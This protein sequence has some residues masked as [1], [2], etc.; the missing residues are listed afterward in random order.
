[1]KTLYESILDDE[2]IIYQNTKENIIR[3]SFENCNVEIGRNNITISPGENYPPTICKN[4]PK[5]YKINVKDIGVLTIRSGVNGDT[6]ERVVSDKPLILEFI[7]KW[8][9]GGTPPSKKTI[10]K[11]CELCAGSFRFHYPIEFQNCTLKLSEKCVN[12]RFKINDIKELHKLR[13]DTSGT[14][15]VYI[16]ICRTPLGDEM[17]KHRDNDKFWEKIDK[18]LNIIFQPLIQ[19]NKSCAIRYEDNWARAYSSYE[20]CWVQNYGFVNV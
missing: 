4:V 8:E 18:E 3:S 1:M 12:V 20:K 10:F 13:L 2:E 5:N 19:K 6:M 7:D 14:R 11:N 9:I 16:D 15:G 17:F